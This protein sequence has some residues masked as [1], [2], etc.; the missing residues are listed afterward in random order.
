MNLVSSLA[1]N[2][3]ALTMEDP[4]QPLQPYSVLMDTLGMTM[5]D[6]GM[7]VNEK[8]AMQCSVVAACVRMRAI[9]LA[10]LPLI[11]YE[12]TKGGKRRATDHRLYPLL[13]ESPN[14]QMTSMVWR[15]SKETQRSLW[16]ATYSEIQRDNAA[17]AVGFWPLPSDRT[18]PQRKDGVLTYVTTATPQGTPR[19]IDARNVICVPW[20]SLDGVCGVSPVQMGKQTIGRAMAMER[21]GAQFFANGIRPSGAFTYEGGELSDEARNNLRQSLQSAHS[22]ANAIR[23]L[24]LENGLKWEKMSVPPDEAQF[25]ESMLQIVA[26]VARYWGVPL[27]LIQDLS[28]ST[29]NN[30]EQQ[31]LEWVMYGLRPDAVRYEQELNR[32]LFSGT[33]FFCEHS[34]QDLLRGDF[35]TRMEGWVALFQTGAVTPNNICQIEG[36]NEISEEEGG[37]IRVIP[38][39]MIA[40]EQVKKNLDEP[41]KASASGDGQGTPDD[42]NDGGDGGS[43][44]GVP[45]DPNAEVRRARVTKACRSLF[46][47]AV[48]RTISRAKRD[49]ATVSRI[50]KPV[51]DVANEMVTLCMTGADTVNDA[52]RQVANRCADD[53]WTRAEQWKTE[54]SETITEQELEAAYAALTAVK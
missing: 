50:W 46:R 35:K 45:A 13:L 7:L 21:F 15:E 26:D 33:D 20:M 31:A 38:M 1:K 47:D 10:S 18:H 42:P 3:R 19:E 5:S 14:P 16:G 2:I 34:M 17:R 8:T 6:S 49:Q 41:Q 48:N 4:A 25:N 30:I 23:P 43:D 51:M 37:N 22:G 32:K 53:V 39:N 29:N 11:V 40:L 52:R 27:H 44:D 12:R 28:R 36:W 9:G 54:E 24:L